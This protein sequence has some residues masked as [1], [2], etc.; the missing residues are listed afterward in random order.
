VRDDRFYVL[1]A[2]PDLLRIAD[3]RFEDILQRRN[4]TPSAFD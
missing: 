4:P 1:A 2:Q 3:T